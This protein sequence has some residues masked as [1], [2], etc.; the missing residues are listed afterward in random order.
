[1]K[2]STLGQKKIGKHSESSLETGA[3]SLQ[4]QCNGI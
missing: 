2:N 4:L 1:M 3:L